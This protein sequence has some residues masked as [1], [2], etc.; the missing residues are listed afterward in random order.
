M[1]RV[2]KKSNLEKKDIKDFAI[3]LTDARN[4][5]ITKEDLYGIKEVIPNEKYKIRITTGNRK[6][7]TFYGSLLGAIKRKKELS[8][9]SNKLSAEQKNHENSNM[10]FSDCIS[11]YINSLLEREDRDNIDINTV[12]DHVKKINSDIA[13]YFSKYKV[14]EVTS[15]VIEDFINTMRKRKNKNNESERISEST[16]YN[17]L[18][19]LNSILN[20]LVLK[21]IIP[22]NPYK[23]VTN[24]PTPRKNKKELNYF[25]IDEAKYALKCLDKF[26]DIRLKTFMNIIFSLG[27]RR[28]EA[29]GL[30][31][32][33]VDFANKEVT[34]NYAKTSTVPK[35]FLKYKIERDKELNN[36]NDN[37]NYN[38]VRT[39]A[40]KTD[41]SYR[42]NYL[43]EAALT[44]LKNY[45]QY[46]VACGIE[47]N[48]EDP[49]FTNYTE[50]RNMDI[51]NIDSDGVAD[52]N[53]PVD[54]VKMSS[55]WLKFKRTYGIK[56]V[57]LHRI[58]H[59]VAYILES[60]GVAKKDIA[61]MLGNTERVLEEYYTHVDVN[62]LK[63]LRNTID[64]ELFNDVEYVE[65]D[66]ELVAKILNEYPI[67]L[68]KENELKK[69]DL[70]LNDSINSDNYCDSI[71]KIK[72]II[73]TD[74]GS[75]NYFIDGDMNSLKIKVD[76]YKRFCETNSI[77][78]K[79]RKVISITRSILSF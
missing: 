28:E 34:F 76:T 72:D 31:W 61:K 22:D 79:K 51:N 18:K 17:H 5:K 55:Y 9:S 50:G 77:K 8:I 7:E 42:T 26:A 2:A 29:C 27:C 16:I 62:D 21:K 43:S 19:T 60:K 3:S 30:R 49:I 65:L 59:T 41:N 40:L 44:C 15:E 74:D 11:L 39:K 46:K 12:Y 45:Y 73:L 36:S 66:I 14:N 75:L 67:T 6:A 38:R 35:E 10:M 71:K 13:S 63:R 70:L 20:Y 68:L 4:L 33:D 25:R 57:D 52:E 37:K 54:P 47:I 24:K 78:I 53:K 1:S 56:D 32:K 69:I 58:R 23:Y 64:N 48:P